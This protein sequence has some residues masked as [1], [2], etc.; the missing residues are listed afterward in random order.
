MVTWTT[1]KQAR[2]KETG[3]F[4]FYTAGTRCDMGVSWALATR[5]A[6]YVTAIHHG[7]ILL[8]YIDRSSVNHMISDRADSFGTGACVC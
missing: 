8:Y 6:L 1:E 4:P 7:R 5:T 3:E 2:R